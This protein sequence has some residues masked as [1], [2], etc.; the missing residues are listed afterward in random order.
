PPLRN[1]SRRS[2]APTGRGHQR[3]GVRNKAF[4]HRGRTYM[5][6][7]VDVPLDRSMDIENLGPEHWMT[8]PEAAAM[9]GRPVSTFR[10]WFMSGKLDDEITSSRPGSHYLLLRSDV[11]KWLRKQLKAAPR[12][13]K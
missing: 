9:C 1:A 3:E 13:G 12:A 4:S 7:L 2:N 8:I 11:Q 5:A 6:A 10:H